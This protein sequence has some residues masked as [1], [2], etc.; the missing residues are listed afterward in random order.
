MYSTCYSFISFTWVIFCTFCGFLM[1][2]R[3]FSQVNQLF[4]EQ[5]DT[6]LQFYSFPLKH[7]NHTD[8]NNVRKYGS[9]ERYTFDQLQLG[10]GTSDEIFNSFN[11]LIRSL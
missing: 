4:M 6:I 5:I 7:F 3:L 8:Y 9:T 11:C 1:M 10:S 2:F